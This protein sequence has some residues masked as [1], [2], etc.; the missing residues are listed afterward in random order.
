MATSCFGAKILKEDQRWFLQHLEE[1][2]RRLLEAAEKG[3][4]CTLGDELPHVSRGARCYGFE[5]MAD[6]GERALVACEGQD[7]ATLLGL[8][9]ELQDLLS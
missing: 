8:L 3:D 5:Q 4:W 6:L 7:R 1:R 2:L 9:N